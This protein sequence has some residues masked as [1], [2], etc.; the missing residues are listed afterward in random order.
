M[1]L[2]AHNKP[3]IGITGRNDASARL[4]RVAMHA[5]GA[6]Y[7][8]AVYR[9]GGLPVILPP[10]IHSEDIPVLL[11]RLDGLLLSGGEDIAPRFY[12]QERESWTGR[13]DAVRDEAELHLTRS[14]VKGGKPLL[15]I[16]RGHQV[17]NVAMGGTLYQDI[18]ILIPD[19]LDHAYVP[20]RP[21]E[22][23]VHSVTLQAGSLL[24]RI[25][26]GTEF[27]VNSAHH[28]AV[29]DIA[30][31]A[32]VVAQAPDGVVEALEIPRLKFCIGV[33]WHPE[34]MVKVSETM[35]PLF[36]AFIR[37]CTH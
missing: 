8:Q 33:Q 1:A 13:V 30:K 10:I 32:F 24:A 34:A 29:R 18:S 19:S 31:G 20:T 2:S 11:E 21:M 12:K 15:A 7:T 23:N 28:Q 27:D 26:G 36:K 35:L 4:S 22:N 16:C 9:S 6:T 17:L 14:W 5:V 3:L 25:L 37:A